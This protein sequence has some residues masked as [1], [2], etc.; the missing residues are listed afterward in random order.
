MIGDVLTSTILFEELRVL[1]PNAS[2]HYLINA[3]TKPV[4]KEHPDIDELVLITP[5]IEESKRAFYT[6]LKSIKKQHYDVVIDVYSKLSSNLITFFSGAKTKISYYKHYSTWVYNHNIKRVGAT[7]NN[8]GLAIT[9]R[10]QLLEPLGSN[11]DTL[12]PK[13]Y[14]TQEEIKE[15][16]HLLSENNIDT[17]KPLIMISVLGSGNHKTYPFEYMAKVIDTTVAE[18]NATVLFNYIPKQEKDAKAIFELC[19]ATTKTHIKFHVFGKSLRAF[20]ALLNECDAIIG[21][22]GGAINMAKA[23]NV[24][25]FAIYAPWISKATWSIFEDGKTNHSVHLKEYKPDTYKN[26]KRLKT[27]L[28]EVKNLYLQLKPELF[29]D[30]LKAFLKQL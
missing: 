24:K 2:L 27:L 16:K 4:V 17:N 21:N 19:K 20:M 23:L 11:K 3:H 25:T 12:K 10:L 6:F 7:T 13:I 1:Y 8:G 22:E 15:A 30:K 9:N 14:L 5:E 29:Q 28:P 26:A 18:T